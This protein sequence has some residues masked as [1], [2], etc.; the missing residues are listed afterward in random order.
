MTTDAAA[1]TADDVLAFWFA[2]ET[3]AR[4]FAKGDAGFDALVER[5]LGPAATEAAAGRLDAWAD[6]ARGALALVILLDQV[7]RN[8]RRGSPE[9][10]ARD[11]KARALATRAVE[12]GL[13]AGLAPAERLFLYLP[14]EHSEDLA[15]Q[16]RSVEL[17]GR[18]GDPEWLD[19]AR[20]HRAVVARF[21][22]FPHRNSVLGRVSTPEEE[23][24]LAGPDA[25]F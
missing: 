3:Q 17:F 12:R 19:Y 5:R 22:R 9:A 14:F 20:R 25:P 11:A 8:L 10:F 24:L 7:P 23:A 16:D 4:W 15:D 13:D 6:T 2:P 18:I 1:G 21:G